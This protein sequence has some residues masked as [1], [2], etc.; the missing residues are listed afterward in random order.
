MLK[1]KIIYFG[2]REEPLI[3]ELMELCSLFTKGV[4][5][6]LIEN[7]RWNVATPNVHWDTDGRFLCLDSI[8]KGTL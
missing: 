7:Q 3:C 1:G 6:S 4:L 8:L 5:V 2:V